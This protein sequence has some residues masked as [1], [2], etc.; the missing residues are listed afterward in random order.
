MTSSGAP[1]EK[2][3][4]E[5]Y[6]LLLPQALTGLVDSISFMVV[7]P[8]VIF[9]VRALGGTKEQ[10]GVILSAFSFASFLCKP[11]LG[12][13]CDRSGYKF[14]APYLAS[15]IA[16]MLGGI[17]Y[18]AASGASSPHVAI[19]TVFLG[20]LLGGVGAANSTL[21]FTYIAQMIPHDKMTK[22]S[23]VLSMMRV[24]G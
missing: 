19:A 10:Y 15:L 2:T 11:C 7:S 6:W 21:G 8:S 3:T 9:Y 17:L 1:S 18:F 16:A 20:R 24:L 13:W 5:Y 23:T 12:Y 14:R 4:A 22:F